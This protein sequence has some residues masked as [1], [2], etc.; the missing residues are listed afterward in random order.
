[1]DF[2]QALI[3]VKNGAKIARKGWNGKGMFIYHVPENSYPPTTK[4][5]SEIALSDLNSGTGKV[6]YEA[7]LAMKTVKGTVIPWLISQSDA[8]AEDWEVV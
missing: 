2:S 3:E 4:I 7:Y 6:R 5:G 8:L 1:M